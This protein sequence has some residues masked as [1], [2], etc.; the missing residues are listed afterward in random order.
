MKL[1]G[2]IIE[3][4]NNMSN[5]YTCNR[6]V[7]EAALQGID[8]KIIGIQDTVITSEGVFNSGRLLEKRN[9]VINRYKWGKLKDRI[10]GLA[11][12]SYNSLDAYNIYINKFEQ[13]CRLR[14]DGFIV[15]LYVLGT[16]RTSYGYLTGVLGKPIVAKG[17]ESSMGEQICLIE[18]QDDLQELIERYGS[19]KEWLFE[20]YIS[21]SYGKDVR[22]YSIQGEVVA[23]MQRKSNGDFRANVALGASVEPYDITD[24]IRVIAKDIYMQTGLDFLGIDLMFGIDRPYFCEINVMPG[25]KGIESATGEN[26]AKKIIGTIKGDLENE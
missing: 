7:E 3:K 21:T 1:T 24:N 5:A 4:Y 10:N 12:R 17:L 6:L 19:E 13:V 16:A 25:I 20:E 15:P 8:L 26:V 9:F 18:K 14:S 11:D 22:F 23:C 2:Y